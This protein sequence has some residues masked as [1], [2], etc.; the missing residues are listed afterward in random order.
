LLIDSLSAFVKSPVVSVSVRPAKGPFVIVLGEVHSPGI[1]P[2]IGKETRLLEVVAQVGG[3]TPGA[4]VSRVR[5]YDGG[6][7]RNFID[8][9]IGADGVLFD[10]ETILNPTVEAGN[11]V[12]VPPADTDNQVF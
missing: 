4:D 1:V 12:Y 2:L 8:A 9:P 11:I 6:S 7:I 3:T 5:I 10:G